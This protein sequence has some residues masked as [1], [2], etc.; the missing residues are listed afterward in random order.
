MDVRPIATGLLL[1]MTV[2]AAAA[3]FV[4][5]EPQSLAARIA[6]SRAAVI[7]RPAE[8][9]GEPEVAAEPVWTVVNVLHDE[10]GTV[11]PGQSIHPRPAPPAD[12][13][14]ALLL[15]YS[16]RTVENC[17][18][19]N[20]AAAYLRSLP[21]LD[22]DA[23]TRL[24]FA[25][26]HLKAD[27]PLMAADAFAILAGLSMKEFR[28]HHELL[29]R[30]VLAELIAEDST[31]PE[32]VGLYGFLLGLCGTADDAPR[33]R[34]RLFNGEGFAGGA[35]GVAA[36]YLLLTGEEGLADL[37]SHVLMTAHTSPLLAASVLEALAFLR[38]CPQGSFTDGRLQQAA[39][40][41]LVR[42]DVA[43]LAIGHLAASKSWAS[44]P[45]VAE[46]ITVCDPNTDQGRA[47]QVAATRFLLECRRDGEAAPELRSVA[48]RLL[49][50]IAVT[51]S[52]LLRRATRLSGMPP[53]RH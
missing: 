53:Q 41:G 42:P 40:C 52:D 4:A 44:L 12:A 30:D 31:P 23:A 22:A 1:A 13:N 2:P 6:E 32:R 36:G 46:L 26:T 24:K 17:A 43:D 27:D 14:C 39:C 48:S 11:V 9:N 5:G 25:G 3:P 29:P 16:D 21:M 51:D 34:R 33:L 15:S 35:D 49:D 28:Q 47:S 37:E 10:T 20:E 7:V 45:E 38:T 8:P 18:L 19:S 50:E